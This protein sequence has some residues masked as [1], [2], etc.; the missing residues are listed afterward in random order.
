MANRRIE[1]MLAFMMRGKTGG[2]VHDLVWNT[3]VPSCTV[4]GKRLIE[5]VD[6]GLDDTKA[7][8]IKGYSSP[9]YFPN[10]FSMVGVYHVLTEMAYPRNWHYYTTPET[11]VERGDVVFDCGSAEGLFML[12]ARQ[13]GATGVAF[14]P[15]PIYLRALRQTFR[16]DQGVLLVN[17]ALSNKTE[18]GFLT[19]SSYGSRVVLD[20]G[21][22]MSMRINIETL[23]SV[24][25]RLN[26]HPTY[27]KADIEGYEQNM[28]E[29]AAETISSAH[30]KMAITTYH[31]ENDVESI[32][33]L[34]KHYYAG[35]RFRIKGIADRYGKSVMLH[36]WS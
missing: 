2:A 33:R 25:T 8:W 31:A 3:L 6:D 26:C 17:S 7:V 24:S 36:A 11:P 28:L 21:E 1:I 14:E 13:L 29:G 22:P 10:E 20:V 35:Y 19:E 23:D 5:R 15:H 27:I 12:A 30:P 4:M 16:N 9:L 18:P 32:R 34:I